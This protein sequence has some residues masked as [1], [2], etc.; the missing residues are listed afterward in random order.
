MGWVVESIETLGDTHY[1]YCSIVNDH[2]VVLKSTERLEVGTKT[3]FR[4]ERHEVFKNDLLV[5]P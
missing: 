2:N 4:S 1:L 5:E 3:S